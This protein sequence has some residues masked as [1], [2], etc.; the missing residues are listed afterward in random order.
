MNKYIAKDKV[1][2]IECAAHK[3]SSFMLNRIT[4]ART[5]L[6][7]GSA[8]GTLFIC[9]PSAYAETVSDVSQNETQERTTATDGLTLPVIRLRAENGTVYAGGQVA[10]SSNIGFLGSKKF[11]DTPFNTI[12]YTDK[13][14]ED[15]QAKDITEVIASTDPSIYTNGASGG[16]SENYYIRGFAASTNDMSMNGLFGITP[17]YR[18][19]PEMFSRVEVLKGP[20]ALL[21]GM[22]PAGSVGGAV[23]LVTKYAAD[24]PLARLTATYMSDAQFGGHVDLGRRFGE[25]KEFGVR[26]NGMYRDGDAAVNDQAKE[27]RLFSLGLDWQGEKA[28]IFVDAYDA[29]DHVDGVI[30]GV[31]AS[32]AVGIPKPPKADTLLSPD[33]GFVETK[34]KGAMI[35]GEYDF[36]DQLTAYAVYGQSKTEYKYNGAIVGTITDSIGT[37][38]TALGQLAFQVDK[39]SADAGFKGKFETGPVKHQWVANATY[40]NHEQDDYGYRSTPGFGPI[41]TNIYDPNPNWGPEPPFTSPFLYHTTLSI[42]S[43][44]LADTLSFAQDKVQL[45]LGLRQQ[46]VKATNS[47]NTLPE[48]GKTATT[49]GAALLIKA[50]D[51]ISV[52]ANYIE[53][54]T[55]GE[56][57]SAATS[58]AGVIF[59]PQK[60]KQK[61]LGLKADL[62][63]FA[64]TLSAFEITKPSSYSDA[65]QLVNDLP[66]FVSDGE[67]R[68]RGVEWSF[69]GSPI[70]H[71]RLMGG[72]TYLDPELTN[73]QNGTND[74]HTAI[75]LPKRQAKL[76]VEWD[77][78]VAPGTLTLSGNI[79]AVSRQYINAENTLSVPGRTLLDVGARYSTKVANHPVTFRANIYNLTNKAYWAQPQLTNLALGAP[80]TYM[81]SASYDF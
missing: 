49:P 54:L 78:Q 69:F 53:G 80:R 5:A 10:T 64:H 9:V 76:G 23:N 30:R 31:N 4:S 79:N 63:T 1:K 21:N 39:K 8:L 33:W 60:T 67:Q 45:T 25:N 44:G 17:F 66:T 55:R 29:L 2:K 52:Y 6:L 47:V 18:T 77:T 58:N 65:S 26:I 11:L 48:N 74:G 57:A 15:K 7:F 42:S 28:R 59:P 19:S 51:K 37:L 72:F 32:T 75:A 43:I 35:R 71:V 62:G 34:D 20:S 14:I 81:L 56:Q 13:Y 27:N 50:T 3:K 12:S 70:E 24:E 41:I 38:N 40:Y 46:T 73:T 16:W 22:P 36:S 68:N 61:E